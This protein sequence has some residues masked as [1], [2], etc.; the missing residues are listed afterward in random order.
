MDWLSAA[1]YTAGWVLRPTVYPLLRL[2]TSDSIVGVALNGVFLFSGT[3][4]Y[5]YDAFFPQAFG[6]KKDPVTIDVDVCLGSF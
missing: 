2:P 1:R 3:S 6:I 5:G 4:Q